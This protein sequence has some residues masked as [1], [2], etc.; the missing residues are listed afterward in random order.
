[1]TIKIGIL[2]THPIQYQVPWFRR[3]AATPGID[4]CVYFC[5]IPNEREQGDGFGIAFQWDVPLLDGYRYEV[6]ENVAR[7]PTLSR[8]DGCDTPG[9]ARIVRDGGFDA[10]FVNGW[11]AKSCIQLLVACRRHGVPCIVRGESNN[12]RPRAAWKRLI[13]RALLSQYRAC[14]YIGEGN[15]RFY[16]ENGVRQEKLFFAPYCIENER[17]SQGA[18]A[19]RRD[20]KEIRA[21]WGIPE[22]A[23]IFVYCAKFIEKKRPMDILAALAEIKRAASG[24]QGIHVLMVGTGDLLEDCRKR[25][26]NEDLPVTFAGFLNQSEITRAYAASDCMVLPSDHGE[27][28]GLVVNEGM[29]C[30]LPAI[31]SDQVGCH[32]DL[33][34]PGITGEVFPMGD[35]I[36]LADCIRKSA[37]DSRRLVSMGREARKRVNRYSYDEVVRGTFAALE[38]VRKVG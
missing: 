20:R 11:V 23:V 31:V 38:C 17:F 36:A 19:F 35:V 32:L 28:W 7:N 33:V 14:L 30:G 29:A 22:N 27:T 34:T 37:E 9:I 13:H 24:A 26:L 8:F 25:A 5:M 15:K 16:L 6:L 1:M 3:L 2:T 12:L 10:F 21:A 4:L 18:E